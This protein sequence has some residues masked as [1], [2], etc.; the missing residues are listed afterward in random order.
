M[1]CI[2]FRDDKV[3]GLWRLWRLWFVGVTSFGVYAG[4]R[5]LGFGVDRVWAFLRLGICGFR[6]LRNT[7]WGSP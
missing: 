6:K 1:G 5:F 4:L 3:M 2:G 7:F